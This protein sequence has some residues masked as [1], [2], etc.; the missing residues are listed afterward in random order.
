MTDDQIEHMAQRFLRWR[1]PE[2]FNPDNGISFKATFNDHMP[3]GPM[4]CNPSGTDL[5]NYDQAKA[6]VLH[7][8]EGL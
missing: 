8:I 7:M 1:L 5:F 4:K 6:M 3:F 2:D